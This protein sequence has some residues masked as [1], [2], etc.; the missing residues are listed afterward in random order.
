MTS[1]ADP[2]APR[3]TGRR[4]VLIVGAGPVGL[5]SAAELLRRGVDIHLVDRAPAP[6]PL[7]KALLV[8]P[9]TLE[10]L[11]RLADPAGTA[12]RSLPV[13]AFHY[14]SEGRPIATL[15]LTGRAQPVILPQ[16]EIEDLLGAAV[17]RL[18]GEVERGTALTGLEQHP[19]HVVAVLRGADGTERRAEYA[20][21]LGCD[22]AGSTVRELLGL[23]FEG[24]TYPN[25]FMLV[26]A[27]VDGPLKH[28]AAHYFCSSRGV[29]VIIGLP[30][31]RSRVFTSLPP[32]LAPED[33][34]LELMQQVVDER[35]PGG[36]TL[37]DSAWTSTFAVHAR[38]AER[39]REG[40]VFLVGDAAHIHSPA[41]GQGL[42]TGVTDAQNLAWKLALVWRGEAGAPLLDSYHTERTQVA[43]AVVRQAD[44]QTRAWLLRKPAQVTARDRAAAAASRFGLFDLDYIPWLAGLRTVYGEGRET[45]LRSWKLWGHRFVPG[46]LTPDRQVWDRRLGRRLSLRE[47]VSDL[48]H[49]LLVELP[50]TA[51]P[52]RVARALEQ[53]EKRHPGLL[54]VRVLD[55]TGTLHDGAPAEPDPARGSSGRTAGRGSGRGSVVL[56]RPDQHVHARLPLHEAHRVTAL[57]DEA[58]H[59]PAR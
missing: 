32:G 11:R 44:L 8:W 25:T 42:N 27:Y 9:R 55:A 15:D 51:L 23:S 18:G 43:R 56:V 20:Y 48:Q 36:L 35:G 1:S 38:H 41:G 4:P 12:D 33:A 22:G 26:D 37:R 53:A 6:S 59:H 28:D 10:V 52:P 47:A 2:T 7:T 39:Y 29:L 3:P 21:V 5:T 46:A 40:R 31:G 24:L 34:T 19:D 54:D 50:G 57:L 30:G 58:L 16:P 14:Y 13:D 17:T 49:T 45:R